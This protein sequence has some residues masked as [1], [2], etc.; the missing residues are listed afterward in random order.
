MKPIELTQDFIHGAAW[1]EE[2]EGG[3]QPWRVPYSERGLFP[4]EL[5]SLMISKAAGVRLRYRTNSSTVVLHLATDETGRTV[6]FDRVVDGGGVVESVGLA[7]GERCIRFSTMDAG[8]RVEEIWLS[9]VS[10]I[11]IFGIEVEDGCFCQPEP[12]DRLVW[13][14]YGSSITMCEAA[15][16]PARTWPAV[17]ARELDLNLKCFGFS[18]SCNLD[19]M[20]SRLLR[21]TPA[22]IITLKLGINVYGSS[23]HNQRSFLPA[24]IGLVRLIREKQP[25]TPIGLITSIFSCDRECKPN[26]VGMTLEHYREELRKACDLLKSHGDGKLLLFEGHDLLGPHETH[27]LPDELH[28]GPE[29][30]ELMGQRAAEFILPKLIAAA[31]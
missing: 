21:D 3:L 17:A 4:G 16:G 24:V 1:I 6:R 13:M 8:E 25:D 9:H 28:P 22:D 10:L 30:Y 27:L 29:G 19:P 20:V 14:T 7:P 26:S 15:A 2:R 12:D 18:G 5:L 23:S 31:R 11:T